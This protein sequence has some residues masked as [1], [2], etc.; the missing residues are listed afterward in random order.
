MRQPPND[1]RDDDGLA[2]VLDAAVTI[3]AALILA[4]LIWGGPTSW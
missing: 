2:K 1:D 4:L 3:V